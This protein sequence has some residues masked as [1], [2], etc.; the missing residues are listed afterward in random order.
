VVKAIHSMNRV[1]DETRSVEFYQ[2]AFG[3]GI[4]DRFDF[5]S[6]TLVYIRNAESDFE[7]ELTINKG[8]TIRAAASLAVMKWRRCRSAF[9]S[10]PPS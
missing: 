4:A 5:D 3:L 2:T 10:W 9:P 7:L 1:L 8:T 6:F